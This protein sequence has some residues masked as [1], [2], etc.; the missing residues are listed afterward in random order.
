MRV[1]MARMVPGLRFFETAR[2]EPSACVTPAGMRAV[3]SVPAFPMSIWPQ[4]MSY[5]LPSSDVDLVRPV[6][7]CLLAV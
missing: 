5:G 1:V 4:A 6:S 3:I 2:T 7:A